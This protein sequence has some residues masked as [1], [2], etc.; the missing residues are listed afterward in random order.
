M[1]KT[2]KIVWSSASQLITGFQWTDA[3]CCGNF[4]ALRNISLQPKVLYVTAS[5]PSVDTLACRRETAATKTA[6][7]TSLDKLEEE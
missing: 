3:Q 5:H 6:Q 2:R 7:S 4:P 1:M